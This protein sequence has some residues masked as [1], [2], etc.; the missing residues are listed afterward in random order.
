MSEANKI[1][2][3]VSLLVALFT[4]FFYFGLDMINYKAPFGLSVLISIISIFTG[5]KREIKTAINEGDFSGHLLII[6]TLLSL[7]AVSLWV[8]YLINH[9]KI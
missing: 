4:G 5:L 9:S 3:A 2:L 1:V 7:L 8:I 6:I